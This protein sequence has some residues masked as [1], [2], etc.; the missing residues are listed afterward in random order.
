MLL[1]KFKENKYFALF[2][3]AFS[4]SCVMIGGGYVGIPIMV[5][6]FVEDY[7]LIDKDE[8]SDLVAIAQTGPG[9]IVVNCSFAV[10]YRMAG[11]RGAFCSMLGCIAPPLII[12]SIIENIYSL[13]IN[14]PPVEAF[15]GG[16]Q[17]A[18]S[19]IM[20]DVV[21]KFA[22]DSYKKIKFAAPIILVTAFILSYFV[23]LTPAVLVLCS[24]VLFLAISFIRGRKKSGSTGVVN[25]DNDKEDKQ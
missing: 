5:K 1:K 13:I 3:T 8:M 15:F 6:R 17:I 24:V 20:T 21:L 10:G 11:K 12:I 14:N 19:A 7:K 9:A 16:M 4:I 18:V 25:N 2:W 23:G 22:L